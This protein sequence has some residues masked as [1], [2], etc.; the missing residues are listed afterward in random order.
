ME[1]GQSCFIQFAKRKDAENAVNSLYNN[2]IIKD[3]ICKI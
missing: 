3:V 1:H 2:I